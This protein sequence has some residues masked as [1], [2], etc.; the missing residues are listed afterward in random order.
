[1]IPRQL[2]KNKG[3]SKSGGPTSGTEITIRG[4]SKNLRIEIYDG[5]ERNEWTSGSGKGD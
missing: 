5:R 4:K 1:M 3:E 2:K